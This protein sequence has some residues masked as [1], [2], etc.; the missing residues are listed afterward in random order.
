MAIKS[1]A[2]VL[3]AYD[4]NQKFPVFGFGAKAPELGG[5]SHCFP[6]NGYPDNPEV[7]G[8]EVSVIHIYIFKTDTICYP[9]F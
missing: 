9:D 6:L 2:G 1:V 7:D 5:I 8:V 4:S 3:A